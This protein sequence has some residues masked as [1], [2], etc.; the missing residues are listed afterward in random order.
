VKRGDLVLAAGKGDFAG[1]PRPALVVRNDMFQGF[2]TIA[3]CPITS[4]LTGAL[5]IRIPL[6]SNARTGL[7]KPSEVEVDKLQ[8]LRIEKVK[9]T[10]GHASEVE[11][12]AV[13]L[14]LRR[15]LDL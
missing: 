15:W 2:P 5:P 1:K 7:D 13:D 9:E 11:M 8:S 10:I 4:H 3:L 14:A 6:P 12:I